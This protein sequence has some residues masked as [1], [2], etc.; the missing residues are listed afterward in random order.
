M[1]N[2]RLRIFYSVAVHLSFTE[3]AEELYI[4]QP[5]VTKNIKELER[6]LGITLFDR[7]RTGISLTKAGLILFRYAE[8]MTDREKKLEFDLN[9]LKESF[10]GNLKLGA[11]T[12]IGQYVLP[13]VLALFNNQNPD[14]KIYLQNKNTQEVEQDVLNRTIDLGVVEGNS[15]KKELKY[16]PFMRDE[17]VAVAHASRRIAEKERITVEE[18]KSIPLVLR[19]IGSGSLDVIVA[20]LHKHAVRLKDLNIK[21]HLGST[22]SIKTFAANSECLA[23]ISVNAVAKEIARGE[24]KIIDIDGTEIV[25]SFDFVYPQGH[26]DGLPER[27]MNFVTD[28]YHR[29]N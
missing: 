3:A 9:L 19:E 29:K 28:H 17:I 16:V 22:E 12:T 8:D 13:E 26:L 1:F 14:V 20:E 4:T 23:L 11:S 10:S 25:R 18:L 5:A 24:F 27:F 21:M 15:R 2:F 6:T 7:N